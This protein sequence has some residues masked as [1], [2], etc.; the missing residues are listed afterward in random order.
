M[1]AAVFAAEHQRATDVVEAA[2][3]PACCFFYYYLA[4]S[5]LVKV[6]W[7]LMGHANKQT[8]RQESP[9]GVV[10]GKGLLCNL[11]SRQ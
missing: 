10:K 7:F 8:D 2:V 9:F 4:F 1:P 3:L 11:A 5:G 6:K